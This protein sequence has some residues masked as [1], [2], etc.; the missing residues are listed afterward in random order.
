M[1]L[2]FLMT[3]MKG[4]PWSEP[5]KSSLKPYNICLDTMTRLTRK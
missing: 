4:P 1:I 2:T 5:Y 3:P